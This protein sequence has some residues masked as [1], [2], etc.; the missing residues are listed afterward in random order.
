[1]NKDLSVMGLIVRNKIVKAV[2]VFLAVAALG[3]LVYLLGESY[4]G[5][6]N[7]YEYYFSRN[8]NGVAI[9]Y[10]AVYAKSNATGYL[11]A[12]GIIGYTVLAVI[13]LGFFAKKD[14]E[15]FV[16]KRLSLP[17]K[18]FFLMDAIVNSALFFILWG[19]MILLFYLTAMRYYYKAGIMDPVAFFSQ[20]VN[21]NPFL[22]GLVP[23]GGILDWVRM[24]GLCLC[25]GFCAAAVKHARFAE[26]M[27]FW[28]PLA[29]L[30]MAPLLISFDSDLSGLFYSYKWIWVIALV[31]FTVFVAFYAACEKRQQESGENESKPGNDTTV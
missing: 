30:L 5:K 27:L 22:R 8:S 12:V 4:F 11:K 28:I 23:I 7:D 10:P 19:C 26:K 20:S 6:I 18:R 16:L 31:H 1:M 21:W 13:C 17:R 9:H 15:E 3:C 29:G 24:T 25:A 14:N 2:A